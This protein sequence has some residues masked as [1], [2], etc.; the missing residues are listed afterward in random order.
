MEKRICVVED[1]EKLCEELVYFLNI[2]GYEAK[3]AKVEEYTAETLLSGGFS[4]LLL[5]ISL[6]GTDGLFLCREIRQYSDIPIIILTSRNTELTELMS[7]NCGADDFVSKPV[8]PQILLARME[9][10]LKR[11]YKGNE[12]DSRIFLNG[13]YFDSTKGLIGNGEKSAELTKNEIKIMAVFAARRGEIISRDEI[14]ENLWENQ[15]FVDDNTLT[16]NMTRLKGKLEKIG[17]TNVIV[18]KRGMG[19]QML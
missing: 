12:A 5:D 9:A 14:M 10:I 13:F 3:A 8:N 18:T 11:V 7:M 16:V 2:N 6:P 1:D 4:M 15:L 19:Y 17:R